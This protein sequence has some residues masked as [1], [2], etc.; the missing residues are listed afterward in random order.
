MGFTAGYNRG[1]N[2]IPPACIHTLM[3]TAREENNFESEVGLLNCFVEE[4]IIADE[5]VQKLKLI[6]DSRNGLYQLDKGTGG[7]I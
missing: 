7:W 3:K 2:G 4:E 1:K 6:G 5:M